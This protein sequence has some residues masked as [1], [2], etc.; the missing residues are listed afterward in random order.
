VAAW[1]IFVEWLSR[2]VLL[3]LVSL[4]VWSV[5]IILERRKFFRS[6]NM[7]EP[8]GDIENWI[9]NKEEEKI[10]KWTQSKPNNL[11]AGVLECV[12]SRPSSNSAET[13]FSF[14]MSQ[15]RKKLEK[16]LSVLGTL[17]STAPFIGLFGT[18]LGII[19]AFGALSTGQMD[20]QKVMYSLAEALI[21]TAVGLSVAIPS[22]IAFNIYSGKI[23]RFERNLYGIKDLLISHLREK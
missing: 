20:S 7:D 14:Y 6:L 17:G 16:G 12:M 4:S 18:I 23:V 10:R 11:I 22:V 2:L 21:L 8:L 15:Q 3:G 5:A 9:R 13:A 1:I 19:V